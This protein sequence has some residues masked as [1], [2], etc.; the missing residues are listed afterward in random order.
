MP[1]QEIV[2]AFRHVRDHLEKHDGFVEMIQVV[3]RKTG[4]RI[5]VGGAQ[6]C[7]ARLSVETGWRCVS[8]WRV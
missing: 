3:G 8:A 6:L 4:A 7:G 5:D 2:G 1:F